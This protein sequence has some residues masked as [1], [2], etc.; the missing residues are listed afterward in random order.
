MER[1]QLAGFSLVMSCGRRD[2]YKSNATVRLVEPPAHDGDL[3]AMCMM[4]VGSQ[5]GGCVCGRCVYDVD[6]W[7]P[8]HLG[9][10]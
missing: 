9:H 8:C 3:V 7:M 4:S 5:C 1:A 10:G 2:S 6:A